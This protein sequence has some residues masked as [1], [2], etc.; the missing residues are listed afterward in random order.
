MTQHPRTWLTSDLHFRHRKVAALRGFASIDEHDEA[1]V[2]NWNALVRPVDIVWVLGDITLGNAKLAWPYVDQL[3]GTKHLV[4]GNHD[5]VHPMHRDARRHQPGWLEHFATVQ[6]LARVRCEGE[7]VLF[8]HHP[9]D[10]DSGPGDR[11]MQYR[12]RDMGKILVHGHV[13]GNGHQVTFSRQ[14]TLQIHVGLDDH[15][16]KPVDLGWVQAEIRR[17]Q[18]AA[19]L[20]RLGQELGI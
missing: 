12:L 16:L 17:H 20:T 15:D 1:I 9:Y 10:G 4:A 6:P 14:G 2:A 19:E 13:H 11:D 7:D 18:A 3:A 5:V 8:A